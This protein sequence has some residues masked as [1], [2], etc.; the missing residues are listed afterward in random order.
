METFTMNDV[1]RRADAGPL[2]CQLA[3]G[4]RLKLVGLGGVGCIVLEFLAM[5]L[6]SLTLPLRLV[7]ID[8]D[9]FDLKNIQRMRFQALGNK[10]QV[11]A[12]ETL[13]ALG[14][15]ALEIVAVPEYLNPRN[16]VRLIRPGDHVLLCVDNHATRRLVA[17]HCQT[18]ADVALFSGGNDGVEPPRRL[19]TYGNVQIAVRRDGREQTFPL[20]RFHPEIARAQGELPGGPNCGQLALSTPQILF[21]NLAVASHMLSA[22]FAYACGRLEYQEVQFDILAGRSMPHFPLAPE[23]IPRPLQVPAP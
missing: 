5:F 17:E 4:S 8:G 3:E 19:G 16:I 18:L 6:H 10:A 1:A 21:A 12:A 22:F 11:K 9:Q 7:L 23:Q 14:E 20:T 2:V 13:E 15:S